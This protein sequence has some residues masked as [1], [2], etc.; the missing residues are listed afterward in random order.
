[1]TTKLRKPI[2]ARGAVGGE[3]RPAVG[4]AAEFYKPVRLM[5]EK[6]G[7]EIKREMLAAFHAAGMDHMAMDAPDGSSQARIRLNKIGNKWKPRFSELSKRIVDRMMAQTLKNSAV[8]LGMSL[9]QISKDFEVDTS[10]LND[11]IEQVISAST[12]EAANLIKVIPEQYLSDVQGAVMRSI[13]TGKGLKDLVPT[14]NR[15]YDG[16]IKHAR[17]VALD[18]TRKAYSNITAARLQALG[19]ESFIWVHT[20]GG[21]HPRKDHIDMSGNEYRY[22]DLPVIGVMYGQEVRGKPGDLPFC[23]C[24]QKP[25]FNW[26]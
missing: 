25:V 2:D 23:R 10:F 26:A 3:L 5:L 20:G 4:I 1:M 21:K 15:L 17:N 19:C 7:A 13:S 16:R 22:D 14:L 12:Q 8:T 6:M 11:R 18:Q 9:R 24:I